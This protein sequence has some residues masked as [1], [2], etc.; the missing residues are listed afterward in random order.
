MAPTFKSPAEQKVESNSTEK[1][2]IEQ[3][4]GSTSNG[5]L[6]ATESSSVDNDKIRQLLNCRKTIIESDVLSDADK[7]EEFNR[8]ALDENSSSDKSSSEST[9]PGKVNWAYRCKITSTNSDQPKFTSSVTNLTSQQQSIVD[10]F[11]SGGFDNLHATYTLFDISQAHKDNQSDLLRDAL[12]NVADICQEFKSQ[13]QSIVKPLRMSLVLDNNL[14]GIV[15][16]SVISSDPPQGLSELVSNIK[17]EMESAAHIL[18]AVYD[19]ASSI[20]TPI[21]GP[22]KEARVIQG[23]DML[24]NQFIKFAQYDACNYSSD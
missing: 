17:F 3:Q 7:L 14:F 18:D 13:H 9:V 8:S 21:Y 24:T 10:L 15:R 4:A 11:N 12:Q 20:I 22:I 1:S 23:K 16:L 19:T 2:S 5:D 6:S